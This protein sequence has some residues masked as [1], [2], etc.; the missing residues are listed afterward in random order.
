MEISAQYGDFRFGPIGVHQKSD[1]S[2]IVQ[3][4]SNSSFSDSYAEC[5]LTCKFVLNTT[6]LDFCRFEVSKNSIFHNSS[7]R[8]QMVRFALVTL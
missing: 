1:Y 5:S 7:R 6:T 4:T 2:Q 3:E 8:P